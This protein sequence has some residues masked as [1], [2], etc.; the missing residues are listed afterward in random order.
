MEHASEMGH[1]AKIT[2]N[3]KSIIHYE[4]NFVKNQ[5]FIGIRNIKGE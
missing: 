2:E 3:T 1:K 4:K 5:H